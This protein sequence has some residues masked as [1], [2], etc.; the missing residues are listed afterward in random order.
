MR[1]FLPV[2]GLGWL[3]TFASANGVT[4]FG[5]VMSWA[6]ILGT[7]AMVVLLGLEG[8]SD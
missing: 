6:L 3:L 1:V 2:I 5:P 4:Q 7:V 8:E